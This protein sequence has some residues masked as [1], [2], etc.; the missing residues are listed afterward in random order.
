MPTEYVDP[1]VRK[2]DP[3]L[4]LLDT[5]V[6]NR[7]DGER[8]LEQ[9]VAWVG[10]WRRGVTWTG[11]LTTQPT[12]NDMAEGMNMV[13]GKLQV[14][15]SRGDITPL[16]KT[17]VQGQFHTRISDEVLSPLTAK[18]VLL[19]ATLPISIFTSARLIVSTSSPATECR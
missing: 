5:H 14:G 19:V 2:L 7:E 11:L 17:F 6:G 12:R 18:G 8:L 10:E 16:R 13:Q 15:W 3:S 9:S 4:L 1:P